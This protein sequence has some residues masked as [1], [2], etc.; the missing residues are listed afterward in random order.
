MT[1]KEI[2]SN[3]VAAILAKVGDINVEELQRARTPQQLWSKTN[4]AALDAEFNPWFANSGMSAK[5][6]RLTAR[7]HWVDRQFEK[8]DKVEKKRWQKA[9]DDEKAQLATA[10]D[11]G[12]EPLH[13]LEPGDLQK[14][15][16][17]FHIVEETNLFQG[18][19]R[20]CWSSTTPSRRFAR[21]TGR[22]YPFFLGWT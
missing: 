7:Q 1:K 5:T 8:L 17:H 16:P 20:S 18:V 21:N 2:S 19:G 9:A 10:K 11:L 15:V 3:P 22:Q 4:K 13:R 12:K 6:Q 14:Y